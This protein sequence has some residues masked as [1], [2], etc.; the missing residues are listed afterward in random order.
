MAFVP[1]RHFP[2]L[3]S[4]SVIE[5][6]MAIEPDP[7]RCAEWFFEDPIRELSGVTASEALAAGRTDELMGF[8]TSIA[9]GARGR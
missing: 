4:A 7:V 1:A 5:L 3:N 2:A 8:L 6:C 9:R